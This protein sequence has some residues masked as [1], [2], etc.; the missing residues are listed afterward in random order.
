MNPE[1]VRVIARLAQVIHAESDI[2]LSRRLIG[3][4]AGFF[5][6][7]GPSSTNIGFHTLNGLADDIEIDEQRGYMRRQ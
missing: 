1:K 4:R 2:R 5:L 6:A 7:D 3:P